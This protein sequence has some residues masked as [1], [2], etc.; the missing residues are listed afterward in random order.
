MLW[1]H[2]NSSVTKA[3]DCHDGH[4]ENIGSV[5]NTLITSGNP[6]NYGSA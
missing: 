5:S 6:S 4:L 2:L 3:T 1:E